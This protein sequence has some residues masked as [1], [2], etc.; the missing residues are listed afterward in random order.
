MYEG[1]VVHGKVLST[2]C[3]GSLIVLVCFRSTMIMDFDDE[4]FYEEIS[5]AQR[6]SARLKAHRHRT[7]H[8]ARAARPAFRAEQFC[9]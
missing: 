4:A 7:L 3:L 8:H 1:S 9:F 6:L 2:A 5:K